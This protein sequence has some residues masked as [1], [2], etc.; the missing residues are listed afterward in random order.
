M[1]LPPQLTN[2][3]HVQRIE[4]ALEAKARL[5][6]DASGMSFADHWCSVN[7][8]FAAQ[9]AASEGHS[10]KVVAGFRERPGGPWHSDPHVWINLDGVHT[11][12]SPEN[13]PDKY[14][15]LQLWEFPLDERLRKLVFAQYEELIQTLLNWVA[16]HK[17]T[18]Y[19]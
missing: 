3:P 11:E 15:Y 17:T 14:A 2:I 1:P 7:S 4:P 10:V 9:A 12:C 5:L 8:W 18:S 6:A 19:T 16:D 13:V